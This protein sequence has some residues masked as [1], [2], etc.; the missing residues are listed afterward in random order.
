MILIRSVIFIASEA[1]AKQGDNALG[2]VRLSVCPFVCLGLLRA[3]YTPLQRY[4]TILGSNRAFNMLGGR[5]QT[6]LLYYANNLA[7]AVDRLLI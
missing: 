1:L 5:T 6:I 4:W 7:D 2:G 3:H